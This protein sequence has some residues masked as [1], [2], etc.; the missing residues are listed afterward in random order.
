MVG[1]RSVNVSEGMIAHM[2]RAFPL[3]QPD[4][5]FLETSS[6]TG[7]N[8]ETP[9]SLA[10]KSILLAIDSGRINPEISGSGISYG[11]RGLR[12]VASAGG[13]SSRFSFTEMMPSG[14]RMG[15]NGGLVGLTKQKFDSCC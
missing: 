7:E 10:S 15:G 11:D 3:L 9:F 5:L 4:A 12:R 2:K 13:L 14:S 1:T 6:L 8:V